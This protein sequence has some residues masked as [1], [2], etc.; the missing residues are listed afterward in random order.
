M[1]TLLVWV[2]VAVVT[3]CGTHRAGSAATSTEVEPTAS[4]CAGFTARYLG[5]GLTAALPDDAV[6]SSGESSTELGPI[7]AGASVTLELGSVSV[8]VGRRFGTRIV[9]EA[10]FS[11]RV[12]GEVVVFVKSEDAALR[13]CV[14]KSATY[15]R[16]LDEHDG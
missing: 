13:E 16:D 6:A 9:A 3:S 12:D 14:L 2:G 11:Q 15:R 1:R 4:L 7:H 8:T 5:Q 10:Y